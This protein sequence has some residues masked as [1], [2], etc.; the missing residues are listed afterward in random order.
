MLANKVKVMTINWSLNAWLRFIVFSFIVF[1]AV[2]IGEFIHFLTKVK[3]INIYNGYNSQV[4]ETLNT[5]A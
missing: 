1:L 3:S 5:T 4:F 2:Q